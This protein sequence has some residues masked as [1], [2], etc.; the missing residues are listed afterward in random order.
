MQNTITKTFHF[1]ASHRLSK[2]PEGHKCTR[3]HGH[4]YAVTLTVLGEVDHTGMVIDYGELAP[5]RT[6]IDA[7]LDHRHLGVWDVYGPDGTVLD[8][9][10]LDFEP[11]A[12]LLA[13]YLLSVARSMF[14]GEMAVTVRETDNTSATATATVATSS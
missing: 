12:E 4:N 10:V 9:A 1:S 2:L 3:L 11:T 13:G 7:H 14:T 5:F 8:P 6:W